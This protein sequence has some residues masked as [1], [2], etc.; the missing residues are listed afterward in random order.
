[1]LQRVVFGVQQWAYSKIHTLQLLSC[2]ALKIYSGLN[3]SADLKSQVLLRLGLAVCFSTQGVKIED[4][5]SSR[6]IELRA[7]R[8]SISLVTN[9]RRFL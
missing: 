8:S 2:K 4:V 1:M 5:G 3:V 9:D 6:L 7:I